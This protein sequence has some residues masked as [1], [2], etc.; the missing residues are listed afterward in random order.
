MAEQLGLDEAAE[1][2]QQTEEEEKQ[3]DAK[4]VRAGLCSVAELD[5]SLSS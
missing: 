4:R 2:L 3:A 5:R 1:L